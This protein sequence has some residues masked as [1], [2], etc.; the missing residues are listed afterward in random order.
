M[1]GDVKTYINAEAYLKS[2]GYAGCHF[3]LGTTA[4]TVWTYDTTNGVIETYGEISGQSDTFFAGTYGSYSTVSLSGAYYKSQI[5]SG[6]QYPARIS[7]ASAGDI[8]PPA[9]EHNFVNGECACGEKDPSYVPP[10]VSTE[11]PASLS[12]SGLANKA[13]GD[14]Y[15]AENFPEWTITGKLGAGY[16]G[17]IGFGRSNSSPSITATTTS[18]ITSSAFSTS[19]AFTVT[20]VIKG[21]GSNGVVTS[22]LTFTLIDADGNTVAT[23]YANGSTT[24]AITPVDAKDT[25]YNISFTFVEGKTWTDVSNLVV[26]FAKATGNIGLKSLDFYVA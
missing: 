8:T 3:T 16:G 10:V 21:N 7:L 15:M 22:T 24:A 13:D 9:H 4:T 5:A 2:N 25:T 17:Y 20:A 19:T 6:S 11:L 23:G 26:T 1:N 18:A 12:F 14:A